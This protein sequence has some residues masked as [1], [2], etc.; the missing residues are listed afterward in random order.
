MSVVEWSLPRADLVSSVPQL[1]A[2]VR[3]AERLMTSMALR[4]TRRTLH[5]LD[6][7]PGRTL[8]VISVLGAAIYCG[9]RQV[10]VVLLD[11]QNALTAVAVPEAFLA[12]QLPHAT[13]MTLM[14]EAGIDP[15]PAFY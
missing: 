13:Y 10:E 5:T 2:P 1:L 14:M 8:P 9:S 15:V 3:T 12:A 6:V 11:E 7:A 4:P